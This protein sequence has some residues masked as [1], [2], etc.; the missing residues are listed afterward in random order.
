MYQYEPHGHNIEPHHTSTRSGAAFKYITPPD[1][2]G[3][4]VESVA[5]HRLF[6]NTDSPCLVPEI[7]YIILSMTSLQASKASPDI[8]LIILGWSPYHSPLAAEVHGDL[9]AHANLVAKLTEEARVLVGYFPL[10]QHLR[11]A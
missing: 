11:L 5:W 3:R 6:V 10:V 9:V 2:V 1:I 8:R 7:P 4:L